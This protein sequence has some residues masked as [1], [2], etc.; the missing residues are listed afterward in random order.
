[1][2]LSATAIDFALRGNPLVQTIH[3]ASEIDSTNRYAKNYL[4]TG[5]SAGLLVVADRQSAGQ[6]RAGRSWQTP[7]GSALAFTL[8]L[9]P[10]ASQ[11]GLVS[12]A[13]A[14]AVGQAIRRVSGLP[15]MLKWPNDVWVHQHKVCGVL[16]QA[17]WEGQQL[18]WLLLGIGVNVNGMPPSHTR[19][20]ASTLEALG[21]QAFSRLDLL[22]EILLLLASHW[23]HINTAE[24]LQN[25][26]NILL[27]QG[28]LVQVLAGEQVLAR[29]RLVGL[30][31][32]GDL[33]IDSAQGW[34]ECPFGE[35]S[36]REL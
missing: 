6:G 18:S 15:A 20:P 27:W 3:F 9:P 35:L 11:L 26:E 25:C 24:F 16:P 5:G 31:A 1:M 8:T 10:S 22:Q 19:T 12:L 33:R 13:G 34:V 14:L 28:K 21:G 23:H 29:G 7:A 30:T 4:E 17:A 36:L 2:E 32:S